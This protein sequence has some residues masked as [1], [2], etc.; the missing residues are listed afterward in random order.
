M[1]KRLRKETMIRSK[2]RNK[3]N[4]SRNCVNL[5][6]YRKQRNKC[7]K[8]L[9]NTKQQYF[10]N[11]NSK[12]ITDTKKFWKTVKPPCSNKNKTANTINLHENNRIIKDNK[13]IPHTFNKYFTDLT[14]TL[15]LK[16]ASPVLKKKS[17]K[18]LLRHFKNHS[19]KKIKKHLNSKEIFTFRVFKE[20]EIIR[21]IK[22]LLKNKS[23]TFKDIPVK[24][25]VNSFH[26][27]SQVLTNT[28]N[29]CMKSGNFPDILKYAD[30]TQGR[31][32]DF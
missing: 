2:L 29:D 15:K 20:T 26:I 9:K 3:F 21:K 6:N 16:K 13:K 22:E 30:I 17:L 12:S 27:N 18:H 4:K 19:T 10:N 5:Q 8:A 28:F 23:S 31:R 25:M 7:T 32:S 1:T 11:L 14:K 24:I